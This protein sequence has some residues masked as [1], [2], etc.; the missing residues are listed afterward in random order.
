MS[1]AEVVEL[2]VFDHHVIQLLVAGHAEGNGVLSIIAVH[3]DRF[4][5]AHWRLQLVF[6][7][8]LEAEQS[9]KLE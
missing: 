1:L 3:E 7:G 5:D 2:G 4:G 8:T 9:I 6:D